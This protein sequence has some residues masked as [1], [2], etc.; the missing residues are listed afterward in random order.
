[1]TLRSETI[2]AALAAFAPDVLIVDHLPGGAG[3]ELVPALQYLRARGSTRCVLGLRD[4]LEHPATVRE[5]W[6]RGGHL[7]AIRA[8]Y[9]AVW[10]YADPVLYDLAREYNLPGDV[11]AKV[12]YTGYLDQR[13]RLEFAAQPAT[14]PVAQLAL[15]PGRLALCLVGG[16]QDGGALAKAFVRA[17]TEPSRLPD[18]NGVVLT[19]PFMPAAVRARLRRHAAGHPR[20][21]VLDFVPEPGVLL[22][23]ADRIVAMGGY[24]TTLEVLSFEKRALIVP[25]GGRRTEQAIRA[26]RLRALGLV[27][28]LPAAALSPAALGEWLARDAAPPQVRRRIDLDGLERIPQLVEQVLQPALLAS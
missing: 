19:G 26:E 11:A 18:T 8:H 3:G 6:R 22:R 16:G 14:D 4:V 9:D 17:W 2:R 5:E 7:A 27:D 28:V 10:V 1:V 24:N 20:L 12:L 15:P 23:R 25:R 13:R 21:R